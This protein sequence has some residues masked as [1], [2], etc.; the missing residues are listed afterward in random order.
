MTRTRFGKKPA[1]PSQDDATRAARLAAFAQQ[2]QHAPAVLVMR[3]LRSFSIRNALVAI[4]VAVDLS[5]AL[6]AVI[7]RLRETFDP[8]L[9]PPQRPALA[10][11]TAS[12]NG[13]NTSP[14]THLTHAVGLEVAA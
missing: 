5:P 6:S 2:M 9:L 13:P 8:A 1:T 12:P 14:L 7:S 11:L 10:L 4:I 3:R